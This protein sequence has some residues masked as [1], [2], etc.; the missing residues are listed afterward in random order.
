RDVPNVPLPDV[1]AESSATRATPPASDEARGL[2]VQ[3]ADKFL[4]LVLPAIASLLL[5]ATTNKLCQEVA[6]IPFLWVLPLS[7]YLLS[8][9]VCFDHA[10]WYV[11]TVWIA[12]LV[13]GAAFVVQ[14]L[15]AGNDAPLSFQVIGYS[16][17]LFAACM[18]CHGELY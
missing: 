11:R 13:A 4:W 18:V 2:P 16:V 15:W 10:R 7:L 6:V 8:F 14:L 5:L 17:T 12:L 9:I 1:S 3:R